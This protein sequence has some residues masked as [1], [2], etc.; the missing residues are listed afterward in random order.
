MFPAQRLHGAGGEREIYQQLFS[1]QE[2]SG[3][4]S[5][6]TEELRGR[7]PQ[8]G[9][10]YLVLGKQNLSLEVQV[11]AAWGSVFL[12]FV[13]VLLRLASQ[14]P[15]SGLLLGSREAGWTALA[16]FEKGSD[17]SQ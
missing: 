9:G 11:R 12:R 8:E 3:Q 7:L 4:R 16:Q 15:S 6:D 13:R 2:L 17:L 5:E 10:G 1:T 14:R